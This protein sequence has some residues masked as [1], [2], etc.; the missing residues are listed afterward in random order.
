MSLTVAAVFNLL[1]YSVFSVKE[2][3]EEV[4]VVLITEELSLIVLSA[5]L[6]L[7]VL[8]GFFN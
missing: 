1:T 3:F 7:R 2:A 4:N 6:V 8:L 5:D